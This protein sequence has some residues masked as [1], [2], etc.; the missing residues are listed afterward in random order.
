MENNPAI[1]GK[2]FDLPIA[3][4]SESFSRI[5]MGACEEHGSSFALKVYILCRHKCWDDLVSLT[6]SPHD[7]S[8][9][10]LYLGDNFIL[11]LL[12][13]N[14]SILTSHNPRVN[15]YKAFI[16]AEI[17]CYKTNRQFISDPLLNKHGADVHEIFHHAGRKIS[18]ILGEVPDW[19]SLPF[20]FG[21]GSSLNVNKYTSSLDKL[22]SQWD[23][24]P[25]GF[26]SAVC[27]MQTA[28]AW[29]HSNGCASDDEAGIYDRLNIVAGSKLSFV[30]KTAITDR[31]ICIEPLLNG[32]IQKGHGSYIRG[33][34]RRHGLDINRAQ[35][36]HKALAKQGSI[37]GSLSTID[38]SSASDTISYM[39][40]MSLL[41]REWFERLDAVRSPSYTYEGKTY[42]FE[43][44][45]SMGN[46]YT[47]ELETLIFYA[48]ALATLDYLGLSGQTCSVY[49]DDI[50]I[51]TEAFDTL[52]GVLVACG[53]TVNVSKSF[54]TGPFRESCGGDYFFGNDVRCFY[55]KDSLS[56]RILTLFVNFLER[57]GLRYM[58]PKLRRLLLRLI[59]RAFSRHWGPDDGTDG[60]LISSH[61]YVTYTTMR[62]VSKPSWKYSGQYMALALYRQMFTGFPMVYDLYEASLP[63]KGREIRNRTFYRQKK[64]RVI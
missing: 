42:S 23:I 15:A 12:K 8:E 63:Y 43:K 26:T 59:P 11:G 19:S 39:L 52:S 35:D 17:G 20:E 6:V 45:S 57:K 30:P 54:S 44:F 60:H 7:Y 28:P 29:C 56:P 18:K 13:K 38:L 27:F 55:L 50:I 48:L 31:P 14:K 51:P 61:H 32:L 47:F 41:P 36:A 25:N 5:V 62:S 64:V 33:R 40:I 21:P 53:F 37:T 10:L 3:K 22:D 2:I 4:S 1:L 46:G 58:F 9:P 16:D 34:L 24:T 49:G